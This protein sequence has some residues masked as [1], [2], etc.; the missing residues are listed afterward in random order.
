MTAN[1]RAETGA[2]QLQIT[3]VC[4]GKQLA[5]VAW[6]AAGGDTPDTVG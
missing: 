1:M 4:W 2:L 5:R 6:R 3:Q